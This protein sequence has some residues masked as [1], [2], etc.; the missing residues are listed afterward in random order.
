LKLDTDDVT[1]DMDMDTAM[2]MEGM[3]IEE[4]TDMDMA[5]EDMGITVRPH[6]YFIH[7]INN[8]MV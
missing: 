7:P 1:T 4:G 6:S 3:G 5:T 8:K 2:V